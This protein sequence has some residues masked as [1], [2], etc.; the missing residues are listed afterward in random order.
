MSIISGISISFFLG[1]TVSDF[2]GIKV[3]KTIDRKG[4]KNNR[5]FSNEKKYLVINY[6]SLELKVLII[7]IISFALKSGNKTN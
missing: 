3:Y 4:N 6:M 7:F 5:R 2:L 1:K